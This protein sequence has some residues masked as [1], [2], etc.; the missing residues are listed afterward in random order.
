MY[1]RA[2]ATKE[3][4]RYLVQMAKRCAICRLRPMITIDM[5]YISLSLLLFDEA[6]DAF[7]MS[8]NTLTKSRAS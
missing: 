5:M 1:A 4:S 3:H 7:P 8:N 2:R 6:L